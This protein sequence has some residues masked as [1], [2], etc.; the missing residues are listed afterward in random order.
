MQSSSP[1]GNDA[2]LMSLMTWLKLIEQIGLVHLK[3]IDKWFIQSTFLSLLQTL[4]VGSFT[5]GYMK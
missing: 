2:W 5:D 3:V 4:S 1:Q